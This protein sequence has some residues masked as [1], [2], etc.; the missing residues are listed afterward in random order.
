MHL[1]TLD[2]KICSTVAILALGGTKRGSDIRGSAL[3][4]LDSRI[5]T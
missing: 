1:M 2:D 5:D 3:D 4:M